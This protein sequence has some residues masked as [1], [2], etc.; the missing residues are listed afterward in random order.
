VAAHMR[1]QNRAAVKQRVQVACAREGAAHASHTSLEPLKP[2]WHATCSGRHTCAAHH[3]CVCVMCTCPLQRGTRCSPHIQKREQ[4]HAMHT[5]G[6][7]AHHTHSCQRAS[8]HTHT[9]IHTCT[10]SLVLQP[11]AHGLPAPQGHARTC[12]RQHSSPCGAHAST[13]THT[14]APSVRPWLPAA[15]IQC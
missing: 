7:V 11:S 1:A 9:H 14:C 2:A 4:T 10:H 3:A 12:T 6:M 15:T 5:Q 8:T 13:P